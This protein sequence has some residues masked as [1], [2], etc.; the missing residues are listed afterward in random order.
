MSKCEKC[1]KKEYCINI[2]H[3]SLEWLLRD[4]RCASCDCKAVGFCC[5][6]SAPI[7]GECEV[8]SQCNANQ[9]TPYDPN[10]YEV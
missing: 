1:E 10:A 8:C 5:I 7:C 6:C 9:L 2:A 3:E 4:I